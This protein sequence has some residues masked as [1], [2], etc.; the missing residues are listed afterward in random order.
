M[1]SL[2]F[3][4]VQLLKFLGVQMV[5]EKTDAA[6]DIKK[7]FEFALDHVGLDISSYPIWNDYINYLRN[8]AV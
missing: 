1:I 5:E 7:A 4:S 3:H 6:E 2:S 8:Q